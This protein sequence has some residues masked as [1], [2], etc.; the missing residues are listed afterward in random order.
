M[1]RNETQK[2][3]A[4]ND[5]A[6]SEESIFGDEQVR[7]RAYQIYDMR[8]HSGICGDAKAD[9]LAAIRELQT[10]NKA[11]QESAAIGADSLWLGYE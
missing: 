6:R 8:R 10:R 11:D 7:S 3:D 1:A 5:V 4:V 9:W 2:P